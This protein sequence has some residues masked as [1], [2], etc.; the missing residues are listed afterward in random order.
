MYCQ[1]LSGAGHYVRSREIVR[2]L[3]RR[4]K[5]HFVV[6]G[7]SVPGPPL[8]RSVRV[9]QLPTLCRTHQGLTPVDGGRAINDVFDDRHRILDRELRDIRPDLL[10]IEHFPFSKWELRSE[11]LSAIEAARAANRRVRVLSSVRDHPAGHEAACSSERYGREVVSLLNEH[12]TALLVH[13]DPRVVRL[14]SQFSWASEIAIPI[15]HTGY[16]SQRL[17]RAPLPA[18]KASLEPAGYV[19]VSSGGLGDGERLAT[20]CSSAWRLLHDSGATAGRSML[21]VAG[22]YSGEASYTALARTVRGGHFQLRR[23]SDEFLSWMHSADLSINQGGYNTTMNVLETRARAIL[24]PNR[25][26]VDQ[27]SRARLL[28]ERN[29]V[30]V[31]DA[32]TISAGQLAD[33]ILHALSRPRPDHALALNGAERTCDLIDD[34]ES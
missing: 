18:H 28:Q 30:D 17:E 33:R 9:V 8:D 31:I 1:H 27:L 7:R 32:E 13:S 29:L 6:G 14:E 21:L 26:M 20:L 23:F 11:L 2:A 24:A 4:H 22:L 10:I 12:F 34:L 16:V 5:V 25:R 3:A 15:H 19:L